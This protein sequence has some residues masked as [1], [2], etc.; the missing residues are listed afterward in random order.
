MS[1]GR[2]WLAGAAA[3]TFL[4]L[5]LGCAAASPPPGNDQYCAQLFDQLD[6]YDFLPVPVGPAFDFRQ[7]QIARIQQARCLT[8]T[9]NL[10]GLEDMV[11][12]PLVVRR[13]PVPC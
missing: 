1:S 4:A 2:A 8:F 6:S 9:R 3:W 12:T 11:A 7:M 5:L 10:V 13:H